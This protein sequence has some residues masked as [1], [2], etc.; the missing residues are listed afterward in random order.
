MYCKRILYSIDLYVKFIKSTVHSPQSTASLVVMMV[1][2]LLGTIGAWGQNTHVTGVVKDADTKETLPFVNVYFKG[3]TVGG[4]TDVDGKFSIHTANASSTELSFSFLGY[5]TSVQK[6]KPGETQTI[7]VLLKPEAQVLDEV[8]V[9]S[10]KSRERYRN[11]N[12][13]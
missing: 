6:V 1:V 3:T 4:V 9:N 5:K 13:P 10:G 11:K 7:N 2:M 8:V 12:N